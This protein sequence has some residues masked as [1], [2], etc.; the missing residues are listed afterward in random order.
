[1]EDNKKLAEQ[2]LIEQR[3]RDESDAYAKKQAAFERKRRQVEEENVREE[4]IR[5]LETE[6]REV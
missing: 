4:K 1:M 6:S 3:E 5:R 2:K